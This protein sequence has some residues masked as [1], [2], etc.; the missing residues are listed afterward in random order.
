ME[1]E[2]AKVITVESIKGDHVEA[3]KK[4]YLDAQDGNMADAYEA[5]CEALII[6]DFYM[7]IV[8]GH[9]PKDRII[10][11]PKFAEMYFKERYLLETEKTTIK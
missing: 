5:A 9:K 6:K 2:S 3:V 7:D 8:L 4:L 11:E 10:H 1:T